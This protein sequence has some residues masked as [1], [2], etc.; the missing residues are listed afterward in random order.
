RRG[1]STPRERVRSSEVPDSSRGTVSQQRFGSRG[2]MTDRARVTVYINPASSQQLRDVAGY[3]LADGSPAIDV[4]CLF[5][6]NYAASEP[7]YL[8]A[9]NNDPP[10]TSPLNPT[11]Q[12]VLDDGSVAYLQQQGLTV[13]LTV[14][15]G[16]N[17]VGWS[18]FTSES[19][20]AAFAQYLQSDIIG[21]YGL[22]GIDIDDEYSTGSPND[23]S[24]IMVTTIMRSIMPDTV[25]SKAL[26]SD[27]SDFAATWNGRTLA[28]NL[29]YGAE[30]SYGGP[31]QYRLPA[32]TSGQPA[33]NLLTPSQVS[34]GFW[35]N[36]P[37]SD[38]SADVAWLQ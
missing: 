23:T 31:P 35:A 37:S 34:C 3:R 33:A 36:Q 21:E 17:P 16:W 29:S 38:P 5:A 1:V 30:M 10:T 24:L 12:S 4:V 6:G 9:N 19:D 22:N 28:G 7:P 14:T 15:N 18:Q 13:L 26:W 20:A 25:I 32:Y 27:A 11:I 8:R 2:A